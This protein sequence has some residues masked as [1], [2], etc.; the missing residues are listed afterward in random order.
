MGPLFFVLYINDLP[1][2]LK[3]SCKLYA[4]DSK[5][6]AVVRDIASAMSIQEDVDALTEWTVDWL[7][8][9]NVEKCK[10]MHSGSESELK[11]EYTIND[12]VSGHRV[13]LEESQCEKDLGIHITAD[14]RWKTHIET[15][16]AKANRILGMLVKTFANRDVDIWKKL[17]VSLVRPHL[18]FASTVWSP[19]L[20]GDIEMLEKVQERAS[21]IPLVLRDLPYEERLKV[22]G[23]SSLRERRIRGDLIQMYKSR[24]ALEDI[25]WFTG[26]TLAP[27]TQTRSASRNE[28]RLLRETFPMKMQNDFCHSVTVR[29]EFFLNRVVGHWNNLVSSQIMAPSLNSFKARIDC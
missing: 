3:N 12:L 20:L 1:E 22:W 9:L 8:R 27:A 23:I 29:H 10:I 21:K 13:V 28:A 17:Y 18:E 2:R 11:I 6:I 5:I 7:L 24:N 14:L 25:D 26:P 4:D 15:I 19:Y 16:A